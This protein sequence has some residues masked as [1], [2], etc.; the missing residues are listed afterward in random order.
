MRN[1]TRNQMINNAINPDE[2]D[3]I[4]SI[5]RFNF[6]DGLDFTTLFD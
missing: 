6:E 5:D 3:Y 2:L 4:D 1:G